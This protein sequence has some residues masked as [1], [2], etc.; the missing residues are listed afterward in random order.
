MMKCYR[1]YTK[2]DDLL[3]RTTASEREWRATH[4][5][6]QCGDPSAAW[7]AKPVPIDVEVVR[8]PRGPIASIGGGFVAAVLRADLARTLSPYLLK[9]LFGS[10]SVRR[11]TATDHPGRWVT[12]TPG[13]G[14]GINTERGK[15]CRHGPGCRECGRSG[16]NWI[17]WASGAVVRRDIDDRLAFFGDGYGQVF[18]TDALIDQLDLRKRFP[19]LRFYEYEVV[20]EPL[21]GEALPGDPDWDGIFRPG[22]PV[23]YPEHVKRKRGRWTIP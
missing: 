13:E 12:C 6:K 5:C 15:Y 9:P 17:G 18:V 22:P 16:G 19:D 2:Y 20:D 11:P 3:E 8:S 14:W 23:Y 7:R 4:A 21:D 1:L 10:V